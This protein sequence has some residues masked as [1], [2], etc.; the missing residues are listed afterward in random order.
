MKDNALL[1]DL[2]DTHQLIKAHTGI[3][4]TEFDFPRSYVQF[5][6]NEIGV[7]DLVEVGDTLRV[8]SAN[9]TFLLH[10]TQ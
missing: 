5:M 8:R 9:A 7:Q 4:Q 3:D 6:A 2:E 10:A 1:H